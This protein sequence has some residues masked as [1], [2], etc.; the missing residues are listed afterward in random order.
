[1]TNS[2]DRPLD[3]LLARLRFDLAQPVDFARTDSASTVAKVRLL[4]AAATCFNVLAISDFGGRPGAARHEGLVEQVVAAAVQ[5]YEGVDPHPSPFAKAAMLLRGITPGHPFVDA[6]KRTGFLV[7]T[8]YLDR[9]G[10]AL[11]AELSRPEVVSFCR[12]VSAGEVRDLETIAAALAAWTEPRRPLTDA[13]S[14]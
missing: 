9:V 11:R 6:N 4:T 10:Y 14:P 3:D 8:Y 12:R 5:A 13:S 1:V 2:G 7:A